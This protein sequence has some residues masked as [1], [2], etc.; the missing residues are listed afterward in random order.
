MDITTAIAAVETNAA[1]VT[2]N[3]RKIIALCEGM[4]DASALASSSLASAVA[5]VEADT[6]AS[7]DVLS[8]SVATLSTTCRGMTPPAR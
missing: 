6:T 4:N 3:T 8:A 1:L 7:I 2:A 5:Q